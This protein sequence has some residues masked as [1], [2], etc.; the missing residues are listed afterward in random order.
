MGFPSRDGAPSPPPLSPF[1]SF[2]FFPTCFWR[3]WSA[4]LVAWCPLPAY[5][6]CFV[7]F[8]QR[9]NVPLRNL[10]GRKW[11]SRPIPPPSFPLLTD[12]KIGHIKADLPVW[13]TEV[14]PKKVT[15][16]LI[17]L[18]TTYEDH[19]REKRQ[20]PWVFAL[21]FSATCKR[22]SYLLFCFT[23]LLPWSL[24]FH[25]GPWGFPRGK[26]SS[27]VLSLLLSL[28]PQLI[29]WSVVFSWGYHMGFCFIQR[30]I[31]VLLKS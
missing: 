20:P 3:Q 11:S 18:R 22:H 24:D 5:R 10:W 2:I 8:A 21:I 31:T 27:H 15:G 14:G 1:L 19:R 28:H 23:M 4:F 13:H 29:C 9:W 12:F 30:I 16:M 25:R 7:K 26:P 6:S 17:R